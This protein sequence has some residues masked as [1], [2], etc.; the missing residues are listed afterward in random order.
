MPAKIITLNPALTTPDSFGYGIAAARALEVPRPVRSELQDYIE[1]AV[2]ISRGDVRETP[3]LPTHRPVRRQPV[4]LAEA[5]RRPAITA[6]AHATFLAVC[7]QHHYRSC[8]IVTVKPLLRRILACS[9]RLAKSMRFKPAM[10]RIMVH[11][12]GTQCR[13]ELAGRLCGPWVGE[14]ERAWHSALCSGKEIEVDMREVI[15]VDGAGRELLAAMHHAGARLIAK[16]VWMTALI[17]EI[18]DE[19]PFDGNKTE[20]RRK[21]LPPSRAFPDQEKE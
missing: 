11:Q 7:Q 8:S 9:V 5:E 6:P 19:Q 1:R 3:A 13:L 20:R 10:L 21:N 4:T 15:G 14:T 2:I 18:V 12:D 17:E 16:G